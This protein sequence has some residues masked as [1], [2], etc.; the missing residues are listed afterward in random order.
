MN[1]YE[2]QYAERDPAAQ[3]IYNAGEILVFS[4]ERFLV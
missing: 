4:L 3:N 2:L 1:K